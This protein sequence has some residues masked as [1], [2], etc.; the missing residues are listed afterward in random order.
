MT[1]T[2]SPGATWIETPCSAWTSTPPWP[3]VRWTSRS[4]STLT[5]HL[6]GLGRLLGRLLG[7]LI[8]RRYW[9]A[10]CRR[11][12][13]DERGLAMVEPAQLGLGLEDERL[14]HQPPRQLG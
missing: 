8:G 2:S 14:Q 11:H 12:I 10:C 4:S 5:C 3:C 9:R 13:P 1:A 6:P 7:G